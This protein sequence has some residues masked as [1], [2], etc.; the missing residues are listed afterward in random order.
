PFLLGLLGFGLFV[1]SMAM[2]ASGQPVAAPLSGDSPLFQDPPSSTLAMSPTHPVAIAIAGYFSG[3][4]GTT[5]TDVYSEI[6]AFRNEGY[7]FGEIAKAF[8]IAEDKG[9]TPS[10]ILELRE[11]MGWGE[12]LK[13]NYPGLPPGQ[14]LRGKNLGSIMSGRS[15]GDGMMTGQTKKGDLCWPPGLCKNNGSSQGDG[16]GPPGLQSSSEDEGDDRG[17]GRPAVPPGQ[18]GKD[19]S[20]NGKGKGNK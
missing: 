18:V 13:L 11:D 4:F 5:S 9:I 1:T 6:T 8:F 20:N 3:T 12:I 19:K 15:K 14:A 7:G 10:V 17:G 16:F 2:A